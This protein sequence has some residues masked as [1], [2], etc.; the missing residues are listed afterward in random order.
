M[1]IAILTDSFPPYL[2]GVTSH[3]VELARS[4]LKKG[5]QVLILTSNC[6]EKSLPKGLEAARIVYL[7]S[8]QT[9][10]PHLRVCFPNTLRV[11]LEIRDFKAGLIET[12][13]PSFLGIDGLVASKMLR[14]PCVSAFHTLFT[15]R[16]YLQLIFHFE[17]GFLQKLS[18]GYHRWF[19]NSSDTIT[20]R[21]DE[22]AH[23]LVRNGIDRNKIE[24]IPLIFDFHKVKILPEEDIPKIK[25]QYD[26]GDKVAVFVGRVSSE[27]RLDFLFHVWS[28]VV[29]EY[30]NPSLLIVGGGLYEMELKKL[31][32]HY[33]LG[34][35]VRMVG[36]IDHDELLASGLISACDLFVSVS[37]TE[38]FG[39]AGLEAMAHGIPVVL[40]QSQGLAEIVGGA[41]IICPSNDLQCFKTAILQ[42]FKDENLKSEMGKI[43]RY[44]ARNYSSSSVVDEIFEKYAAL[45]ARG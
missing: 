28:H 7:P 42:I 25:A 33:S 35:H 38:T 44:M 9:H 5:H 17:S 27:K 26:L 45:C 16:E 30:E 24:K 8:F 6:P 2:S 11:I 37:T 18:W 19:Y 4:L 20:V 1:R 34:N 40:A 21:T 13:S 15:S 36:P 39:L 14:I 29:E 32:R 12:E 10:I 43:A 31:V 41:G 3:Y 22:V 23:L